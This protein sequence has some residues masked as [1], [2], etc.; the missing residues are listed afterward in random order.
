MFKGKKLFVV[1]GPSGSGKDSVVGEA[2]MSFDIPEMISDT[3][4]PIRKGEI[5][6][7]HYNFHPKGSLKKED[8]AEFAT[9][10]GN[11]YGLRKE[12][13]INKLSNN[14]ACY[15]VVSIDGYEQLKEL[16]G[17]LIVSIFVDLPG[18]TQKE[19]LLEMKK[20]MRSRGDKEDRIDE[21]IN[22]AIRTN[23][24]D[25][26]KYCDYRVVNESREDAILEVKKIIM[27]EL[28]IIEKQAI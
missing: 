10:A 8:M 28:N 23:E 7:V 15:V 1:M 20:R 26:W 17:D 6:G 5:D 16:Y 18:E 27:K 14:K 25:N 24:L 13:I 22:N 12:E 9:Y 21:R 2:L 3:D 19:K 4:R 11:T